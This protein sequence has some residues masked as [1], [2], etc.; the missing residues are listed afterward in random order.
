M[1][2]SARFSVQF[3]LQRH[4]SANEGSSVKSYFAKDPSPQTAYIFFYTNGTSNK[5]NEKEKVASISGSANAWNT[6]NKA[7]VKT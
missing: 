5:K 1:M 4:T 6:A 2:N 3:L 7:M